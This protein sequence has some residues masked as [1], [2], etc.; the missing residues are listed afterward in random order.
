MVR[1][2]E[3]TLLPRSDRHK[4]M[5]STSLNAA[6]QSKEGGLSIIISSS[7]ISTTGQENIAS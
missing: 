5:S 1:T 2:L 3:A 6:W 4:F 7:S